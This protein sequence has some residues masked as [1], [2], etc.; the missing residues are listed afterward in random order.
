M[1]FDRELP[2][3]TVVPYEY[4]ATDRFCIGELPEMPVGGDLVDIDLPPMS[5][6][7]FDVKQ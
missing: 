7:R 5:G 4:S 1:S 6:L 3:Q 2:E